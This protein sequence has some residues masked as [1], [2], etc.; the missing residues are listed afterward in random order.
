MLAQK[1]GD[2]NN[3]IWQEVN[4]GRMACIVLFTGIFIF[5]LYAPEIF[6]DKKSALVGWTPA[7]NA[8]AEI[9]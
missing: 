6:S 9:K 2:N 4:Y 7:T 3:A 1:M 5:A 8:V